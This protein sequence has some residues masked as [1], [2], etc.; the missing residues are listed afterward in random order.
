MMVN[1][2]SGPDRGSEVHADGIN[3][4]LPS[5]KFLDSGNLDF[6]VNLIISDGA[7][8]LDGQYFFDIFNTD[9]FLG[10]LP[11]ANFAY[12]PFMEVLPRKYRFRILNAS[13]SRFYQFVLSSNGSAVP[14]T[15]VANDG[16]FLSTPVT[17]TGLDI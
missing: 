5:G 6:D 17:V 1:Y 11:L 16:N 13:M 3:L 14:I 12:A 15:V 10:D 4:R 2:Y 9:G 7:T 8:D